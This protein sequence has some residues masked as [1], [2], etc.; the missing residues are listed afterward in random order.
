M[1]D[2][3][4]FLG[5]IQENKA[6]LAPRLV[7]ADWLEERGD[8]RSDLIRIEEEMRRLPVFSDRF[9]ELKPQR[10]ALRSRANTTWLEAMNYTQHAQ[11][12]FAHGIPD[13]WKE[14]WRL[15]REF[16]E[17]WHNIPMGDVGGRQ[18]EIAETEARLGRTLPPSLREYVAFA[19]DVRRS[20]NYLDVFGDVYTMESFEEQ[21]SISLL[22]QGEGAFLTAVSYADLGQTDP[23]V[24]EYVLNSVTFISNNQYAPGENVTSFVLDCAIDLMHRKGEGGSFSTRIRDRS[25]LL[26]DLQRYFPIQTN[27]KHTNLFEDESF[28][29]RLH[30]ATNRMDSLFIVELVKPIPETDIPAFL[31]EHARGSGS[32]SGIFARNRLVNDIP[33]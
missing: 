27:F 4:G 7:Y 12:I 16:T 30:P 13:G 1:D 3:E 18:S 22:L 25:K 5:T 11:L 28:F 9:W 20:P 21:E 19:H 24:S 31:L 10:N 8:S 29:I 14:R 23:P 33:F 15:I 6:D 26:N 32:G 17:R 2:E